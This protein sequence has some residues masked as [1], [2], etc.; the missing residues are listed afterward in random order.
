[1]KEEG[2]S[3]VWLTLEEAMQKELIFPVR[4]VIDKSSNELI[5][6]EI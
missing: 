5:T 6:R 2:G 1:V 4:Y 3:P